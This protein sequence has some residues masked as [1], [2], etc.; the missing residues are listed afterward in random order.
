MPTSHASPCQ[1][2]CDAVGYLDH[3][4]VVQERALAHGAQAPEVSGHERV[5]THVQDLRTEEPLFVR[6]CRPEIYRRHTP[7]D[8]GV[9]R[10]LDSDKLAKLQRF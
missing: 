7:I 3:L 5:F 6:G 9:K 4:G 8:H 2:T 10:R 1:P